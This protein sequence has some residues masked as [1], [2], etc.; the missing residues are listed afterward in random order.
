MTRRPRYRNSLHPTGLR[1]G[2][3][4]GLNEYPKLRKVLEKE[5]AKYIK[6]HTK[7]LK[8]IE[9]KYRNNGKSKA[10]KN[11]NDLKNKSEIIN[12]DAVLNNAFIR[13]QKKNPPYDKA[14]I[15]DAVIWESIVDFLRKE[16]KI[17]PIFS[18]R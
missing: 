5:K 14:K 8:A 10:I 9:E 2:N 13:S 7:E 3:F 18:R 17:Q 4:R 12:S 15:T 6:E 1:H 11:F 16:T